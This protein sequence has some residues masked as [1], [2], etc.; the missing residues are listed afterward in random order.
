MLLEEE[1]SSRSL[2]IVCR[3]SESVRLWISPAAQPLGVQIQK[4]QMNDMLVFRHCSDLSHAGLMIG[5]GFKPKHMGGQKSKLVP[6]DWNTKYSDEWIFEYT[7][8]CS[9]HTYAQ[10]EIT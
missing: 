6:N 1:L 2:C 10:H 7:R 4:G 8:F 5:E 9:L 3:R